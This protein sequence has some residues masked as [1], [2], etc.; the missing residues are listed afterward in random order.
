MTD[1]PRTRAAAVMQVAD[2][3]LAAAAQMLL[4]AR[5]VADAIRDAD[6]VMTRFDAAR[7]FALPASVDACA[8]VDA[9]GL[10]LST[11]EGG[12]SAPGVADVRPPT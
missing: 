3:A 2:L 9:G 12:A 6:P 4:E 8:V 7:Q 10:V 1:R 5:S 11:A